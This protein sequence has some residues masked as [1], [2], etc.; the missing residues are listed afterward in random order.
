MSIGI[1]DG[2]FNQ[3]ILVPF[4]L[5]AMKLS[6]YY[7]RKR[8]IVVLAPGFFP[9]RHEHFFYRKDYD[10]GC[11]P[12]DLLNYDNVHYG[13][14]AFS[15]NKYFPLDLD[16]EKM[17]ADTSLYERAERTI[18]NTKSTER[19]KIFSNMMTAE[20]CRL[21]LDDKTIWQD[22]ERQF[23][24]LPKARNLMLHD[25]DL[26]KVDKSFETV[27]YI[28]KKART[29]GWATKVGMKFPINVNDG[30]SLLNWSS[31]NSNS[32]FYSLRYNGVIDN[33]AFIE[34][35][36]RCR[37]RAI[38]SQIEYFITDPRYEENHFI[39]V[40][41]PQIFKQVII[42]RSFRV[43][44]SLKYD[45]D[46][47]SDPF[48]GEVIKLINFYIRSGAG[49]PTSIYIKENPDDTMVDFAKATK[50]INPS[51]YAYSMSTEEIRKIFFFVQDRCPEL[52]KNFYECNAR[53][54]GG[55]L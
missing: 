4:N 20:H 10:D 6:A 5:E 18:M 14:Y 55:K 41:L 38:Y 12:K 2:D 23:Y 17:Q 52:F 16:I 30:Q 44:F 22:F 3:Y 15:K 21:S 26:G 34:W 13:G 40:L 31:L 24:F 29:D 46:F 48:W 54:L 33:D 9:D 36:G 42:S 11:Y 37:Q 25:F 47:F 51:K 1:A 35:V 7:K 28:L 8:E 27:Q 19:K 53:A 39:E 43:F 32:T 49:S 50:R 45:K